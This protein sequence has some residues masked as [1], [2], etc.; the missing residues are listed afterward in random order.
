MSSSSLQREYTHEQR[1][2]IFTR[3]VTIALS[4]GAGCG[5]TFVL[6]ERF[7]SCFDGDTEALRPDQLGQLVAITFT[8]RA[9]R[10]MRARIRAK[11]FQRLVESDAEQASHWAQLLRFLDSARIS[12]IHAFCASLLRNLAV[13]ARLD[14]Q[15]GVLEQAQ[16]ETVLSEAID[17]ELRQ[18]VAEQDPAAIELAVRFD[19]RILSE[20]LFQLV[21]EV[22]PER[23]EAWT[24]VPVEQQVARWQA[25]HADRVVPS[26]ARHVADSGRART[27]LRLI[28]KHPLS[29]PTMRERC[30]TLAER[31]PAVG[32]VRQLAALRSELEAL[33]DV[34]RVQ[35]GGKASEWPGIDVK[36]AFTKALAGLRDQLQKALDEID[37][38]PASACEAAELS[39]PLLMLAG[40]VSRRYEERKRE[41]NALDFGDLLSRARQLLVH[42]DH[43]A[44]RKRVSAQ[45]RMLLVDEFQ[46]TDPVQ[47]DLVKALCGEE[48]DRGKLFFVG[49]HKQSI[50]RFRGAKPHVFRQLRERAPQAG[51]QSLTRNFRS[52]GAILDF[53]N[54]LFR[55]EMGDDYQP[56]RAARP[57]QTP[58]PAV[59]F[60][61]APNDSGHKENL[62]Q[63]RQRE[64]NWIA[65]RIRALLDAG[66]P[67]VVDETTGELRAAR[68]GDIAIL[69]RAMSDVAFYEDALREHGIDYY[70]VG[71]SAFYAQQEIFDLLNLLR[72]IDNVNDLVSLTGALRSGLFSL[73]DDTIYWLS[74]HRGGLRAG[75]FD[76][77]PSQLSA[78]ERRKV[79]FAAETLSCLSALKNRVR[80]CELIEMALERT[81]YDALLL[82][83]FLGERKLANLRKLV[84]QA[85]DFQQGDHLGLADFIRQLAVFV[86]QQPDEPLAATHSE[87]TNVVRLMS[88]HQSKGLEFP[89][90][91]VAD[92]NRK[93]RGGGDPV[94]FSDE[95]GPLVRMK[96]TSDGRRC[97]SGYDL[98][99][100]V[101]RAEEIAET[102]RL[103]Y[104]ATTRAADYLLLSSGVEQVGDAENEWMQLVER[105]FDLHTGE[106]LDPVPA[107]EGRPAVRVTTTRPERS[108]SVKSSS[109]RVPWDTLI[110]TAKRA[111]DAGEQ[112][113]PTVEPVLPDRASRRQ[114]SFSR[115]AGTLQR[116]PGREASVADHDADG[117]DA[118]DLGT[119]VHTV[120]AASE[121]GDSLDY[122][123]RLRLHA[124]RHLPDGSPLVAV[125]DE[126]VARFAASPR[127]AQLA[128]AAERHAEV[129]FLLT[130]PPDSTE[131]RTILSGFLDLLYRDHEGGWHIVDF[132]TNKTGKNGVAALA[133][134]YE[135]QMLVYALAAERILGV[136]PRSIVLHF[137]RTGDEHAFVW[138]DDS[139]RRAMELIQQGI[140]AAEQGD[141]LTPAANGSVARST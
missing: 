73:A 67:I 65:R 27:V 30:A 78:D 121:P 28:A 88:V 131:P 115:L 79:A 41:L 124:S 5:K 75:L 46:D 90:V 125:A 87:D 74:Q 81:G 52:Q 99:R 63:R 15:F 38:D 10:E 57:Q 56:L 101:E 62:E 55:D 33:K 111:L 36:N 113:L 135:M 96:E 16:S 93:P 44:L 116:Q 83:E 107:D 105:H 48:I 8:E 118:L 6:T 120:L 104:V 26:A 136:A 68:L 23:L 94:H 77:P 134:H 29:N 12:T 80:I 64:A 42:P 22:S 61:W 130:W 49:D 112:P 141:K 59:E 40:A 95:L 66:D 84:D 58:L 60:L 82:N 21:S 54:A 97:T 89:L 31:L 119:L 114:Y 140:T 72:S 17:D 133:A 51:R 24:D 86:S 47:V 43:E 128:A 71:G 127:A 32:R 109:P 35:G 11:C 37:F 9:A 7:L 1:L 98:W 108:G 18:R 110:E 92:M 45:I 34:S 91:I 25:F 122:R 139:R 69:F 3:D 126:M 100:V 20:M 39:G 123:E 19:L 102:R 106:P 132:K 137:L 129:E 138:N 76:T 13:E 14:P 50:Y 103:L 85:R 117:G 53:V 2:A 70:V 4:A